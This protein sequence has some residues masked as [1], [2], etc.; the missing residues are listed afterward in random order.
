MK[1]QKKELPL[2]FVFLAALTLRLLLGFLFP[3]VHIPV[4]DQVFTFAVVLGIGGSIAQVLAL[5]VCSKYAPE[6]LFE[7]FIMS[8]AFIIAGRLEN[9]WYWEHPVLY[10]IVAMLINLAIVLGVYQLLARK[11][12]NTHKPKEPE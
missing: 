6:H 2:L 9:V 4:E 1:S 8:L 7:I 10:G 3:S 12:K 11:I 5:V